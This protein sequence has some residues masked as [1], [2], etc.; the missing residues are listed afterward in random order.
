M[1][2]I[3]TIFT[4]DLRNDAWT[5]GPNPPLEWF[6]GRAS[7]RLR[8]EWGHKV[9]VLHSWFDRQWHSG[10]VQSGYALSYALL[11]SDKLT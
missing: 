3:W 9:V 5:H 11:P 4:T 7:C 10:P 8:D 1:M 6:H 2:N